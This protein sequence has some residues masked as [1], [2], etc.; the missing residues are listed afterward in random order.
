MRLK[1][2]VL[3]SDIGERNKPII[4]PDTKTQFRLRRSVCSGWRNKAWHGRVMAFME[5]LAILARNVRARFEKMGTAPGGCPERRAQ[6]GTVSA[7][8]RWQL[9]YR[10]TRISR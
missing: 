8:W 7:I 4:I 10:C 9:A 6:A 5:L 3:F 1:G 2:R